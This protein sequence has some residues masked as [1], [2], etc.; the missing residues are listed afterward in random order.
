M[1]AREARRPL[2]GC[3]IAVTRPLPLQ[4]I[5][6]SVVD[7]ALDPDPLAHGLRAFGADVSHVPLVRLVAADD[8]APLQAAVQ[9][10]RSYDWVVFTSANAVRA[11]S[12]L[13]PAAL[14]DGCRVAV[15]GPSTANEVRERLGWRVDAMPREYT[16]GAVAE[17]MAAAGDLKGSRVLWP[18]AS[19]ARDELPARLR[20][21]GAVVTGIEAYSARMDGG[22]ARK[23]HDMLE[24]GSVDILTFTAPSAVRCLTD[25]GRIPSS[26]RIAVI[27]PSSA[28]EAG[29]RGLDVDILADVHT[30]EGLLDSI[31]AYVGRS[32]PVI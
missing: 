29:R 3:R 9:E 28:E 8:P 15:A 11:V 13:R 19:R 12:S 31:V 14:P 25:I 30:A 1:A 27:G 2:A 20:D 23:L 5:G 24:A 16:G 10:L 21:A 32:D 17:A 26:V 7:G 18:K 22:A 6:S 4:A